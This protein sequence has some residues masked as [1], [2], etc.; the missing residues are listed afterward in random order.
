M[1]AQLA[2]I[3][4]TARPTVAT[5]AAIR[6]ALAGGR[7]LR[8][9]EIAKRI[10]LTEHNDWSTHAVLNAMADAGTLTVSHRRIITSKGELSKKTYRFFRLAQ[11]PRPMKRRDVVQDWLRIIGF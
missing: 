4:P 6:R 7:E 3:L 1:L 5:V 10:G 2:T 9:F 11:Q 8:Q